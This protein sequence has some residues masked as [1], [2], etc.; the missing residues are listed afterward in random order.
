[1]R[2]TRHAAPGPV[3]VRFLALDHHRSEQVLW[4]A[5]PWGKLVFALEG[6]LHVDSRGVRYVLPANRALFVPAGEPHP[7]W[8]V[9]RTRVRS[10]YFAPGHEPAGEPKV[11][12]VRPLFRE[13]IREACAI[14]PLVASDAGHEALRQLLKQEIERTEALPSSIPMPRSPGLNEW[15]AAFLRHPSSCRP[16]GYSLRTTERRFAAETGLT[17]GQWRRQARTLVGLQ[18]LSGGA[19]V[20]EAAA[21]AGFETAS[22]FIQAFRRQ[23]G[24]TPGSLRKEQAR[25]G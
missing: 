6:A 22:G 3:L 9:G 19:S 4:P 24:K 5:S 2:Q 10:L 20:Q 7:A 15:A 12:E 21:E 25:E 1:M 11:V 8:A 14:G 23:F 18:A 13:I 16:D 17:F